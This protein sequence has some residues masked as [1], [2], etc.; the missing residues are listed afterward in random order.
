MCVQ[1]AVPVSDIVFERLLTRKLPKDLI[2]IT[3]FDGSF[4]AGVIAS[5]EAN[6]SLNLV[7]LITSSSRGM[8]FGISSDNSM[9]CRCNQINVGDP[10]A[11]L[12]TNKNQLLLRHYRQS[13]TEQ[14]NEINVFR[15]WRNIGVC[16]FKQYCSCAELLQI[17]APSV[18]EITTQ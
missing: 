1:C 10:P 6:C 5:C 16:R 8:S 11:T 4:S 12:G 18:R 17:A 15:L 14:F 2:N 13:M 3:P 7:E 9:T